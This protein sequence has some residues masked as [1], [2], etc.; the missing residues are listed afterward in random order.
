MKLPDVVL[1]DL[2]GTL[3]DSVPDLTTALNRMLEQLDM[4]PVR[5]SDVHNWVGDGS[6]VLVHRAMTGRI[7][8]RVDEKTAS[9]AYVIFQ[10]HYADCC[11]VDTRIFDHAEE[12]IKTL[13]ERGTKTAIVTNKP[14][15]HAVRLMKAWSDR[16]PMDVVLGEV[17]GRPRKPDPAMLLEA[18]RRCGAATT[19]MVGDSEVDG[20]A[21][22]A[23][24]AEFIGVRLGYNHGR[25]IAEM[26]P[27]PDHVFD[28]LGSFLS[29]INSF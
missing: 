6:R 14:E 2:D 10:D 1:F 18:S 12:L 22:R 11:L 15:R 26:V 25:D 21:A 17:E 4:N 23:M 28:E 5:Q 13:R 27:T 16:L 24:G 9:K 29:W 20:Q 3:I 8:G 7:D 19:W